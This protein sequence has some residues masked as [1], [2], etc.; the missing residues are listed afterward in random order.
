M[1]GCTLRRCTL[2]HQCLNAIGFGTLTVEDTRACGYAL[3]NLRQ[4]YGSTWRGEVIIRRC[5]WLP[6][7]AGRAVIAGDNDGS[8]DFGYDCFMPRRVV[9]DGLTVVE[10]DQAPPHAP[11]CVFND[12]AGPEPADGRPFLPV[13]PAEVEVRGLRT[14]RPLQLCENPALMPH[15]AFRAE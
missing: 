3:V 11:L 12:Y 1:N 2:G 5:E 4:D 14:L 7:G 10:N 13:P 15:T 9:I 6:L 8:H